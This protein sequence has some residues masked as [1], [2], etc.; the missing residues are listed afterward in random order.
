MQ[1][2]NNKTQPYRALTLV[3]TILA[4][5]IMTIIF[6]ALLPQFR[7][8]QNSWDT[9]AG[10]SETL[11]NGRVLIDHIYHNLSKAVRITAVSEPSETNG[12]I[13]FFDNDAKN[14]RYDIDSIS[15]YV[16]FGTV[17]ALYDMAGPVSQLLFT[18]YDGNDFGTPITDV[19]FIRFI[20]VQTT[21]TNQEK[22]DQD[23]TFSTQAYI[24]TNALPITDWSTSKLSEPWLKYDTSKGMEPALAQINSTHYLCAYRGDGDDGWAV[25]LSVNAP[26]FDAISMETHFEF[27]TSYGEEFV[28][29]QIDQTHCLC[30]YAGSDDDGYAGV[31][32][33]SEVTLP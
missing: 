13:E 7:V 23:M 1:Y 4:M 16:E 33:V 28:L 6:A 11:Q 31:L 18:C 27:E 21:L 32:Q 2:R 30:A 26:L 20:K 5:A 15:N 29:A 22:L 14:L 24:R 12:Y 9:K 10:A 19:N 3:E 17:G 8:I 25:M